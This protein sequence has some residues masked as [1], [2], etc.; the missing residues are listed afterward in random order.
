MV[1][2]EVADGSL[3]AAETHNLILYDDTHLHEFNHFAD[4]L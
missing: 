4:Y 3:N 2:E 1:A